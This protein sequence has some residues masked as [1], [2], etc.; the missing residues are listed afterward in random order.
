MNFM[1]G[2]TGETLKPEFKTV[3]RQQQPHKGRCASLAYFVA[4]MCVATN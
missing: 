1:A 3:R 4:T 2:S